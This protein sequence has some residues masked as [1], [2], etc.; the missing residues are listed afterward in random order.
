METSIILLYEN[1]QQVLEKVEEI[2][3]K[4]G[5]SSYSNFEVIAILDKDDSTGEKKSITL[6]K[7]PFKFQ[8]ISGGGLSKY[9]KANLARIL[10][11][12]NSKNLLFLDF[13]TPVSEEMYKEKVCP[14]KI[15]PVAGISGEFNSDTSLEDKKNIKLYLKNRLQKFIHLSDKQFD[16][17]CCTT[18]GVLKYVKEDTFCTKISLWDLIGGY[19]TKS[20]YP[21][22]EYCLRVQSL[23]Y[24]IAFLN[25]SKSNLL[26]VTMTLND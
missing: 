24:E 16:D 10:A 26:P 11:D 19:S 22:E 1:S 6:P 12:D 23:G 3:E 9:K 5:Q 20:Q 4:I 14:I 25:K 17:R 8:Y 13:N 15:E 21:H 7:F 18:D 2:T